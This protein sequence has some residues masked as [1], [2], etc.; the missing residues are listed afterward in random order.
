MS[1][2]SA[3]QPN[4]SIYGEVALL[5]KAR[6]EHKAPNPWAIAV[7]LQQRASFEVWRRP[8]FRL[9]KRLGERFRLKR[10]PFGVALSYQQ[11]PEAV[12]SYDH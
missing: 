4:H 9:R 2:G 11:A 5:F 8:T 7:R 12:P 10:E 6:A 3:D 1:L